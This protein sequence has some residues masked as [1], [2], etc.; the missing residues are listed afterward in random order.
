MAILALGLAL[1]M[2][3]RCSVVE[4]NRARLL[5]LPLLLMA[6]SPPPLTKTTPGPGPPS[7]A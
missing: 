1:P 2:S 4:F 6:A 5:L 7:A 3:L